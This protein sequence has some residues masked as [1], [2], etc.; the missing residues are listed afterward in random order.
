M[1]SILILVITSYVLAVMCSFSQ[2]EVKDLRRFSGY[3]EGLNH[4]LILSARLV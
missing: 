2:T 4:R 1:V 3:T